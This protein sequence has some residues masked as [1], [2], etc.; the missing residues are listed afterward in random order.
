MTEVLGEAET[1]VAVLVGEM[2][3]IGCEVRTHAT[4]R[5]HH[6]DGP[7]THYLEVTHPCTDLPLGTVF[8]GCERITQVWKDI[9]GSTPGHFQMCSACKTVTTEGR[10]LVRVLGPVK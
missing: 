2:P 7:A 4:K 8:A 6:D 10:F 9:A 3:E 1:D 5:S